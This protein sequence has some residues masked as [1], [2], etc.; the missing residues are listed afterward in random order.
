MPNFPIDKVDLQCTLN[1]RNLLELCS[2]ISVA[3]SIH[4]TFPT[5]SVEIPHDGAYEMQEA[6][7]GQKLNL[8]IRG[9]SGS[10]LTVNHV[11]HSAKPGLHQ[12][13]R[14]LTGV[15]NGVS[16]DYPNA[17][18]ER[19]TKGWSKKNADQII[20]EIHKEGLKSKFPLE[21]SSGM[22]QA[23]MTSPSLLPLKAIEKAHKLSGTGSRAFY[24]QT[25]ENGGKA[26]CKTM[27][28]LTKQ[29][30]KK[31]FTYK[32]TGA[33]DP[34][35]I[36]D[37]TTVYDAHYEGSPVSAQKHTQ[38]QGMNYNPS[39]GKTGKNE[40]AGQGLS[41]PGLGV[42]SGQANVAYPVINSIEQN[43]EKRH[44]DRDQQSLN[45]YT[46][47]LK[48]LVPIQS[49][50]HAGDVINFN[51]GSATMF[52]DANPNNSAS[53]KWLVASVIHTVE[54]GGKEGTPHHTGRTLIHCIGKIS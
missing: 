12:A 43:K 38:A 14:A 50:L 46:A 19:V 33:A 27:K 36:Y 6:L 2:R 23:S 47:K 34:N 20:Q 35:S 28:D 40:K 7:A 15:I 9:A 42:Q 30:P 41:T 39:Y 22:K 26:H 21:V 11:V 25:T 31:S 10:A 54:T 48:L 8:S 4:S 17:V 37:P 51:S 29:G 53:G 13:G 49:D 1:G 16:P 45:D 32:S 5:T 24:F 3:E 52:S 44:F 18:K